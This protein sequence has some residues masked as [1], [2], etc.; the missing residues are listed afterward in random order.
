LSIVLVSQKFD[1]IVTSEMML[2]GHVQ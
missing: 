2:T 1:D